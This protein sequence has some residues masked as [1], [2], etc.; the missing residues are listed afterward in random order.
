MQDHG[1][2]WQLRLRENA[3]GDKCLTGSS[4][5]ARSVP[6]ALPPLTGRGLIRRSHPAVIGPTGIKMEMSRPLA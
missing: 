4:V 3:G 2:L 5:W 6:Q 1:F